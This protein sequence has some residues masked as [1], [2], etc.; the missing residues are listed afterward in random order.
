MF[1]NENLDGGVAIRKLGTI[2]SEYVCNLASARRRWNAAL[3]GRPKIGFA[4]GHSATTKKMIGTGFHRRIEQLFELDP[5]PDQLPSPPT[6]APAD[7]LGFPFGDGPETLSTDEEIA[8]WEADAG[9]RLQ[10]AEASFANDQ[11]TSAYRRDPMDRMG[12]DPMPHSLIAELDALTELAFLNLVKP[13][14]HLPFGMRQPMAVERDGRF[15]LHELHGADLI[16]EDSLV[17]IKL[18]S[19]GEFPKSWAAQVL[20]YLIYDVDDLYR[21]TS[22]IVY[23][24]RTGTLVRFPLDEIVKDGRRGLEIARTEGRP[25]VEVVDD[26]AAGYEIDPRDVE[27]GNA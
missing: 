4:E 8:A 12:R 6:W 9:S 15:V 1:E 3:S 26:H 5:I 22:V 11:V 23:E 14:A 7:L 17:E 24:G 20:R 2:A 13:F 19:N 18:S 10:E 25:Y 21:F 16:I 27:G